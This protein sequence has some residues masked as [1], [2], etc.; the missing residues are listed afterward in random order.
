MV[1]KYKD[2]DGHE[3][4]SFTSWYQIY[5]YHASM[6]SPINR[7]YSPM[8]THPLMLYTHPLIQYTHLLM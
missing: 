4:H 7:V 1:S 2:I 5:Q 6:Y 3:I 8:Y